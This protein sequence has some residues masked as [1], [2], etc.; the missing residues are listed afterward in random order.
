M[1]ANWSN[2]AKRVKSIQPIFRPN[3]ML[4]DHATHS[5]INR[6]EAGT[7]INSVQ[8]SVSGRFGAL[9]RSEERRV[10]KECRS[11]W[12]RDRYRK[13]EKKSRRIEKTSANGREWQ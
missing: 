6:A 9:D 7:R 12:A 10:G 2:I 8:T 13:K 1:I 11:R 3:V 4:Q 5:H